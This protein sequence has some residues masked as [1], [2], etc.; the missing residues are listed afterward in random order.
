M[1][2]N[3]LI[4]VN[5]LQITGRVDDV[6]MEAVTIN[7]RNVTFP[8]IS[9]VTLRSRNGTIGF[10]NTATPTVGSVNMYN[11]KHGSD[12]LSGSSFNGVPGKYATNKVLPNGTP[13][14]QVKKF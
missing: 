12:L 5:G 1:Y 10:S 2:A 8:H 14:V 11:V 13:A 7:L 4:Q 3:E 9:E 6:Y